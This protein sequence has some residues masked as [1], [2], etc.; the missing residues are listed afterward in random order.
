MLILSYREGERVIFPVFR[1]H[2]ES[3]S[4]LR[5][6]LVPQARAGQGSQ[7]QNVEIVHTVL[8][9]HFGDTF[10]DTPFVYVQTDDKRTYN[11]N[12]V[13]LYAP[14]RSEEHTSELQSRL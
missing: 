10:A 3:D 4:V 13:P 2:I 9:G 7:K 1:E 6:H 5:F 14:Y 11:Q 8:T 12:V